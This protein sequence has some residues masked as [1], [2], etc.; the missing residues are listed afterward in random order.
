MRRGGAGVREEG[1]HFLTAKVELGGRSGS[2]LQD[3]VLSTGQR[4][5]AQTF[6]FA[7]GPWLP[8]CIPSLMTGKAQDAQACSLLLWHATRRPAVHLPELPHLVGG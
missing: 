6:V 3:V 7:C 1:G 5:G 2:T 8:K 4:V